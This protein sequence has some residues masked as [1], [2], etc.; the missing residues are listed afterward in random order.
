MNN[1]QLMERLA[2]INLANR[3]KNIAYSLVA[4]SVVVGI[5]AIYYIKKYEKNKSLYLLQKL[6][7]DVLKDQISR[8]KSTSLELTDPISET[9]KEIDQENIS[10]ENV[11]S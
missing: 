6:E 7:N 9:N 5:T 11:D 4:F 2:K 8:L 10:K 1:N 3:N